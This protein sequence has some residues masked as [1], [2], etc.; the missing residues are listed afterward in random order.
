MPRND[1][2]LIVGATVEELG[3]EARQRDV[4]YKLVD[5]ALER[6]AIEAND[7]KDTKQLVQ[8]AT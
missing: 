7:R 8:L 1:G 2:R 5:P 6:K 3:F 4:F